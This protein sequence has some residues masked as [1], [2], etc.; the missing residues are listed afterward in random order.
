MSCSALQSLVESNQQVYRLVDTIFNGTTYTV[1]TP[2]TETT[3]AEISPAIPAAP[4]A[5]AASVGEGLG[6]RKQLLDMQG[7]LPSGWPFGFGDKPATVAD[8]VRALRND[9]PAQ[10]TRTK[11]AM[12]GLQEAA[13]AATIVSALSNFYEEGAIAVEEG[14]ILIATLIGIMGNTAMQRLQLEAS[15]QLRDRLDR[16]ISSLDGG[17]QAP[18][19]SVLTALRGTTEAGTDRNVVDA[20]GSGGLAALLD[21]VEPLLSDIKGAI[22]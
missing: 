15:L 12:T 2:A 14:G 4:T 9:T 22:Q 3:P 21:Q 1:T 18:G 6:L 17:G 20:S 19:D 8:V 10:V 13:Q 5:A 7:I 11:A 16:L